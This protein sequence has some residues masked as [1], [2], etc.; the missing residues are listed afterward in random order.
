MLVRLKYHDG[1]FKDK[2][3][4]FSITRD[5]VKELVEPIGETTRQWL[6]GGGLLIV[7]PPPKEVE[8]LE[9][10]SVG[11]SDPTDKAGAADLDT[12]EPTPPKTRKRRK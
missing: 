5:E 2:D 12:P 8:A 11:V 6:N 1:S 3:T 4:L 9:V 10:E 7:Q